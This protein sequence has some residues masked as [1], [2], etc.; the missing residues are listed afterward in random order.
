VANIDVNNDTYRA[1]ELLAS[2]WRISPA[3]AVARLVDA[4]AYADVDR[5]DCSFSPPNTVGE[6]VGRRADRNAFS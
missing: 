5:H 1:L 4:V 2:A 6:W 3:D